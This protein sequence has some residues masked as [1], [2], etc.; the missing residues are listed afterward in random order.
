[1]Y[2]LTST[3]DWLQTINFKSTSFYGVIMKY[4]F[5]ICL[6]SIVLESRANPADRLIRANTA[7]RRQYVATKV[8]A[9]PK[10]D[11]RWN[12]VVWANIPSASQF[13]ALEPTPFV[14]M[15]NGNSWTK[16]DYSWDAIWESAVLI[17][18]AG[19]AVEMKIPYMALHFPKIK[20]Q[21]WGLQFSR[22]IKRFG[23]SG[24][25]QTI[26]P[27][28][29]GMVFQCGD[30]ITGLENNQ[31]PL[32]LSL[33]PYIA[34]TYTHTPFSI[35]GRINYAGQ[36]TIGDRLDL[37]YGIAGDD[38]ENEIVFRRWSRH[39]TEISCQETYNDNFA[40]TWSIP[41]TNNLTVKMIY[42]LDLNKAKALL[43]GR[44]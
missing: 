29:D 27:K 32:R 31:P 36:S 41:Q 28:V 11:G 25:C 9:S 38:G 17:Q 16:I 20:N 8:Q 10:I 18:K 19:W 14:A 22:H 42:F 21:T 7:S 24:S 43:K 39:G 13:I 30:L 40:H 37:K 33:S 23:E 2:K 1:M 4:L 3:L 35:D 15:G 6:L 5:L 26:D 44:A 34:N 12:D